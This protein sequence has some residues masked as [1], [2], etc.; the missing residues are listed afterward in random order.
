MQFAGIFWA[1]ERGLYEARGLDVNVVAWTGGDRS[2]IELVQGAAAN[3]E[4]C[5]GCVED[6][7]VVRSFATDGS[8]RVFGAMLQET[9]MVLMSRPNKRIRAIADLRGKRVGMHT[10][11]IRL[12]EM[13]LALEDIPADDLDLVEVGFDLEHLQQDRLDAMQGY[14]MTEPIQLESMGVDVDVLQVRHRRLN[15]YAQ[16]YFS[17]SAL[18]DDHRD[19]FSDFLAASSEGWFAVCAEPDEA[20][21][22]VS[23]VRRGQTHERVERVAHRRSLDRLIPLISGRFGVERIGSIDYEQWQRNLDTYFEFGLTPRRLA[24]RDLVAAIESGREIV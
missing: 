20:V 3:G 12:L 15:P 17:Q 24:V 22:V 8:V 5:A 6:N 10:D 2:V 14:A 13:I 9:P 7:L 19:R 11:G 16:S 18:L 4:L 23:R 1:K 21:E